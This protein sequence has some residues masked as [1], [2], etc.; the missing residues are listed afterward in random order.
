MP[1]VGE[2]FTFDQS[3]QEQIGLSSVADPQRQELADR[4]Q[5]PAAPRAQDQERVAS[6]GQ[7][8]ETR[9]RMGRETSGQEGEMRVRTIFDCERDVK[10]IHQ[11]EVIGEDTGPG[12]VVWCHECGAI[13]K[14]QGP[15]W[16]TRGLSG[17]QVTDRVK[18]E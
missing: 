11:W 9:P 18:E 15:D 6:E 7:Q 10:G 4:Q 3:W 13:G 17:V 14:S 5:P 16:R 8:E 2:K 1:R 12:L